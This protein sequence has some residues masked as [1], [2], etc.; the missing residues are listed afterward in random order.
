MQE[1]TVTIERI[2]YNNLYLKFLFNSI[3]SSIICTAF[4]P[5]NIPFELN[6]SRNHFKIFF[7]KNKYFMGPL[8]KIWKLQGPTYLYQTSIGYFS[9]LFSEILITEKIIKLQILGRKPSLTQNNPTNHEVN[10]YFSQEFFEN[11]LINSLKFP[12]KIFYQI[13]ILKCHSFAKFDNCVAYAGKL[14]EYIDN[15]EFSLNYTTAILNRIIFRTNSKCE[16][17]LVN[18]IKDNTE[19]NKNFNSLHIRKMNE[20]NLLISFLKSIL[21][22]SGSRALLDS[23]L[24]RIGFLP[25]QNEG[26]E[27]HEIIHEILSQ[28]FESISEKIF[29]DQILKYPSY[30]YNYI[31]ANGKIDFEEFENNFEEKGN[32]GLGESVLDIVMFHCCVFGMKYAGRKLKKYFRILNENFTRGNEEFGAYEEVQDRGDGYFRGN[33][34]RIGGN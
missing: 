30:V 14:P 1:S 3:N 7:P 12:F 18:Y 23:T 2:N 34:V 21:L 24:F 32:G 25:S 17:N 9:L 22:N 16:E 29:L 5:I 4:S 11:I 28:I 15:L 27:F 26:S 19:R 6:K 20:N 8:L 33:G 10:K 31:G 13:F